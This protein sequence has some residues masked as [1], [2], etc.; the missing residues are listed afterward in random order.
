MLKG[1]LI[2]FG[3]PGHLNPVHFSHKQFKVMT[4]LVS[5]GDETLLVKSPV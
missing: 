5:D 3:K 2:I 4:F 1:G